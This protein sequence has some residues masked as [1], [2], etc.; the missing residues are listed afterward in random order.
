MVARSILLALLMLLVA[1]PADAA[2]PRKT[3]PAPTREQ[4]IIAKLKH[5]PLIFFIAKGGPNA[6]GPHCSEWIA[7]E[8][9]IDP[10]AAQRFREFL[11]RTERR[12]LPVFI[13][14]LGGSTSQAVA[15]GLTLRQY[16][17]TAGVAQTIPDAC[18]G[19]AM[20]DACRRV[21]QSKAEHKARLVTAGARCASG[22]VY[23]LLGASVRR[24]AR[25]AELGIHSVR[26]VW[27]LKGPA[28]HAPPST[29]I[30]HDSLR[31]YVAEMGEDPGLID[32]A[33]KVS[34]DRIHWMSRAEIEHFGIESR[35]YYETRWAAHPEIAERFAVSK[36]WTRQAVGGG[37]YTTVIRLACANPSAYL[38]TYRSELLSEASDGPEVRLASGTKGVRLTRLP[39]QPEGAVWYASVDRNTMRRTAAE[40]KLEISEARGERDM[41]AF[42]LST[43]GLSEALNALQHHCDG[44][45]DGDAPAAA[46]EH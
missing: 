19:T 13:S 4:T 27:G 36:S 29:D 21:A 39:G 26:Y 31:T 33:A 37:N 3:A 34:P 17:M 5:Q 8:G 38:L 46:R 14:S 23:A 1:W 9:M 18:R 22:C 40:P 20:N 15:I 28:P 10:D 11:E 43:L 32:L 25:N 44:R 41:R 42:E 45:R 24:V 35:G 12:A 7:A 30:V 6:C 2:R 16:R